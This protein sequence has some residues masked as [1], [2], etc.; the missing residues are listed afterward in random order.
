VCLTH[1]TSDSQCRVEQGWECRELYYI[2]SDFPGDFCLPDA[3]HAT[4]DPQYQG[5]MPN[6]DWP[7]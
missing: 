5:E 4:P 6:C 7:W 2:S 3:D 1:C